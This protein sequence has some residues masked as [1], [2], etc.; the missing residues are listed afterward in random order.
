ML[1]YFQIDG[2][3]YIG[4]F[5]YKSKDLGIWPKERGQNLLDT[6]AHFYDTYKTRDDKYIAVG[7][8]EPKFYKELLKGELHAL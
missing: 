7:A 4:S 6:G 1:I 5:V 8:I 2:S 3:A